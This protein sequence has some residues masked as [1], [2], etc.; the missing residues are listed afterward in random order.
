MR[1]SAI[2]PPR[3]VEVA[4]GNH[5]RYGPYVRKLAKPVIWLLLAAQLL[6]AVPAVAMSQ[7]ATHVGA[8]MPCDG[9]PMGDGDHCPCCP[10]GVDSMKDC[11]A[12]CMLGAA[13]P[14]AEWKV[15]VVA[16]PRLGFSE[17]G[18][19]AGTATDPPLNPPPIG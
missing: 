19:T 2:P 16:P 1:H 9:M 12:S 13:A 17:P 10:E 8:D 14:P 4:T 15:H 5:R 18:S 6:L 7:V 3:T 11:L